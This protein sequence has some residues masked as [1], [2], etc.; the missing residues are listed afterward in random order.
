MATGTA[1]DTVSARRHGFRRV[2]VSF[3]DRLALPL[4]VVLTGL[5]VVA[6]Q[7]FEVA[8]A[9]EGLLALGFFTL[10]VVFLLR[11][12]YAAVAAI[13]PFFAALPALKVLAVP[14]LGPTKDVVVFAAAVAA[15]IRAQDRRAAGKAVADGWLLTAIGLVF[16]LYVLDLG[17]LLE[18][19][20]HNL[21]WLHG[22]R[23]VTEPLL[24]LL[25]GLT[26]ARARKTLE[27]ACRSLA[28]TCCGV[29]AYGLLQQLIGPWGLYD[30]GYSFT[31]QLRVLP[32]GTLRSF[33]TLDE[34]FAYAAFLLFGIVVCL[35]WMRPGSTRWLV[36][37]LVLLGL[38]ASTVRTAAVILVALLGLAL[39]A[40][41]RRELA[42]LLLVIALAGTILVGVQSTNNASTERTVHTGPSLFLTLNGR[43]TVWKVALGS[44]INWP[45][46]RGVGVVGKAAQRAAYGVTQS[47]TAPSSSST[48]QAA[49]DSGYLSTV[50]DI[51]IIGLLAFAGLLARLFTLAWRSARSYQRS[52][53]LA[54]GL[55]TV[56]LMDALTRD[57]FTGFP[58]A[59]LGMLLVGL[60][61]A[62]DR[63]AK[64]APSFLTTRW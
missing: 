27:W 54:V 10:L 47:A 16:T 64:E 13:I 46:G 48:A 32:N 5:L 56:M 11:R 38:A 40:R 37:L 19:R 18:G 35:L 26:V 28:A 57:S 1:T 43:T 50:A 4:G 9:L 45:F 12:P 23:L 59:F 53:W 61:I 36:F 7:R 44:P 42:A 20:P 63:D 21:A 55:L 52:G 17:G 58:T 14:S 39:L 24:L 25:Y 3:V 60:C 2:H 34:P 8:L 41:Q 6:A 15:A 22:V 31:Q 29:A 62:A 49:V 30:W 51:G 33:G